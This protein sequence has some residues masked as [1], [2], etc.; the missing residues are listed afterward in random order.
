MTLAFGLHVNYIS[1][2]TGPVA[3]EDNLYIEIL[4]RLN[5]TLSCQIYWYSLIQWN[6]KSI[7]LFVD[8]QDNAKIS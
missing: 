5:Q 1:G 4:I 7:D 6:T 3:F 2:Y 8:Q